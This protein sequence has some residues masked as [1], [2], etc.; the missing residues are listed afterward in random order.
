[1]RSAGQKRALKRGTRL[2]SK[3]IDQ[4]LL[5]LPSDGV[6]SQRKSQNLKF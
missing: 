1:V 2:G 5:R 6:I 3:S 4:L